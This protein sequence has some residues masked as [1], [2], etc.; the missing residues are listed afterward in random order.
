MNN[1]LTQDKYAKRFHYLSLILASIPI[2]I[3]VLVI[4]GW[5]FD[6]QRMTTLMPDLASMKFNTALLFLLASISIIVSHKN[7]K[8]K[9]LLALLILLIS[10]LTLLQY[11]FQISFG[12]DQ[13]FIKDLN[14]TPYPG[15]MSIATAINFILISVGLLFVKYKSNLS[16]LFAGLAGLSALIA[17]SGYIHSVEVFYAVSIFSTMALHTA[18]AF[19]VLAVATILT[20]DDGELMQI[21]SGDTAGSKLIRVMN[22][23]IVLSFFIITIIFNIGKNLSFYP[24]QFSSVL[25]TTTSLVL[26]LLTVFYLARRLHQIDI[27]RQA[28]QSELFLVNSSLEERVKERTKALEHSNEQL[29]VYHS[30]VVSSSEMISVIN[31]QHR[32]TMANEVYT[33]FYQP[34]QQNLI[35]HHIQDIVGIEEYN[36]QIKERLNRSLEGEAQNFELA[37]YVPDNGLRHLWVSYSPIRNSSHDVTDVVIVMRDITD[38]KEMENNLIEAKEAADAANRAKSIFLAN[39]SH[40]LRTPLNAIMGFTQILGHADNLNPEQTEQ[41]FIITNN[42]KHLLTLIN[43]I[44]EMSRIEA[45]KL[46]LNLQATDLRE[47]ILDVHKTMDLF[48]ESKGIVFVSNL[49]ELIPQQIQLDTLKLR[50]VLINL[51]N[52]AIK[53]THVGEVL[54]SVHTEADN[55]YFEIQD[56]GEGIEA[57][58]ISDLFEMFTQSTSGLSAEEGAGLGLPISQRLIQSMGGEIE[59]SSEVNTGTLV[60]FNIPYNTLSQPFMNE[61]NSLQTDYVLSQEKLGTNTISNHQ[62]LATLTDLPNEVRAQLLEHI[63]A[64]DTDNVLTLLEAIKP[65]N[66]ELAS[67]IE[68]LI[69]DFRFDVVRRKLEKLA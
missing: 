66:P 49:D 16:N 42:A 32:Y 45:D 27:Q 52:N 24:A 54:L 2:L 67:E 19:F 28:I 57:E 11:I 14:E 48:A 50:Q 31:K 58:A 62:F 33:Q 30:A 8:L 21:A 7:P 4:F 1:N 51:V 22:P 56:S 61:Q 17:L 37:M 68:L 18:I 10:S 15:R 29:H 34:S 47:L 59:I 60:R 36:S 44:L 53:F 38:R 63:R 3:S 5:L 69:N 26:L 65:S 40:E 12:I 9:S 43:N 6:Y 23:T 25:T 55:L 20:S 41:T 39:M 35:G 46:T 64:L 13:L